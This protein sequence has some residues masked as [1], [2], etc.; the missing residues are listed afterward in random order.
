MDLSNI[1]NSVL[2]FIL[3]LYSDP[4]YPRKLVQEVIDFIDNFIRSV[5]LPSLRDDIIKVLKKTDI[6]KDSLDDIDVCFKKH[7]NVF[8]PLSTEFKRSNLLRRKGFFDPEDIIIGDS[9]TE[10]LVE[11]N[12]KLV[13]DFLTGVT[14]P[15]RKSLKCFLEIPGIFNEIIKYTK[16]LST[17]SHVITNILQ[18]DLWLKKYLIKFNQELVLPLFIFYDE[19][20]VGNALGS[21]AGV[22]KFGAVCASIACLPP[23]IA[24]KLNSILFSTLIYAADKKKKYK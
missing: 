16:Q 13:P 5:Y 11:N 1:I 24:A 3:L 14:V 22:N 23:R 21:H 20:E 7:S 17:E 9:L 19:I 15:L 12:I 4:V 18:G 8:E 2:T 6:N 10:K